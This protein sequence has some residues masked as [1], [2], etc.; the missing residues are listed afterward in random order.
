MSN[1][2][3]KTAPKTPIT[4]KPIGTSKA[5][6]KAKVKVKATITI[7][8]ESAAAAYTKTKV[9]AAENLVIFRD[10]GLVLLAVKKQYPSKPKF[11]AHIATTP[12]SIMSRQD[13]TDAIWLAQNWDNIQAF[14]AENDI[15]SNSVGILRKAKSKADKAA[16]EPKATVTPKKLDIAQFGELVQALCK[17]HDHTELALIRALQSVNPSK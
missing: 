5:K 3:T 4:I 16:K 15:A 14:K 10:I 12:L 9:S 2:K 7:D 8:Y 11:G 13:R 6:P 17:E 1:T